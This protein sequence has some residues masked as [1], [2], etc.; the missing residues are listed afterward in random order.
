MPPPVPSIC[1]VFDIHES[2]R[3]MTS[4]PSP[5]PRSG[6]DMAGAP[7]SVAVVLSSPPPSGD[8]GLPAAAFPPPL[9]LPV[10]VAP[11][12]EPV[13]DPTPELDDA[14]LLPP[15]DADACEPPLEP[16]APA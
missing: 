7:L 10:S 3:R 14:L 12:L 15:L 8:E 2:P 5:F 11:E 9:L 16:A 4:L 1:R 6:C 13:L